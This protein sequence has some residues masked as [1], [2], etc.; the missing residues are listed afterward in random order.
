QRGSRVANQQITVT[1]DSLVEV[2]SGGALYLVGDGH[3][4]TLA[5]SRTGKLTIAIDADSLAPPTLQLAV[6]GGQGVA[7][8][9]GRCEWR[10]Q[11]VQSAAEGLGAPGDPSRRSRLPQ[12]CHGAQGQVHRSGAA[13]RPL[14]A[15]CPLH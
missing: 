7:R 8:L 12:G 4:A 2:M 1:A 15:A 10:R 5:T 14:R 6:L 13:S 9:Y 11:G 3:T